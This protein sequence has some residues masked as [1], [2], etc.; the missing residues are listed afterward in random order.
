[1][2]RSTDRH[3]EGGA[4]RISARNAA[5]VEQIGCE[6]PAS[7]GDSSAP[8]Q[9]DG[10][11]G[12]QAD[13][14]YL[15]RPTQLF[16]G[17][18]FDLDGTIY[19][20]STPLPG[21]VR[22]IAALRDMGRR[23]LFVSNNPTRDRTEYVAKLSGMGIPAEPYD[24]INSVQTM[25][26]WLLRHHPDATV[27][28][29]SE[30]PLQRALREAGIRISDDP[31]EID[32]VIASYD[33]TFDYRKLQ[34]AFD[35]I[36]FHRRARLI[37]T[38][39]D[40]YCPFPGGRGEPDAAAIVAAIEACTGARCEVNTGKPDPIMLNTALDQ[41]GLPAD[42]CLMVG[43]RLSTDIR[44]ARDAGMPSAVV[45][46]GET[47]PA[48]LTTADARER[49]DYVVQRIDQ[50]LPRPIWADLDWTEADD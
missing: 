6:E 17:Y 26:H 27:F 43:D 39:P 12:V 16:D 22:L 15:R 10:E 37:T 19:L 30:E 47:R 24:I 35:A 1:L 50:L 31:V 18:I 38:N 3:S 29:I 36:W 34:I 4:R 9:N 49:P 25:V 14:R 42:R 46:T 7:P 23:V 8:P 2:T 13:T 40:R 44:M 28:P 33:R 21:A 20:G 41:L 5:S 45:L 11:S 48:M 32:F